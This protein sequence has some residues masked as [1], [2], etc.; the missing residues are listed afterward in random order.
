VTFFIA[1]YNFE[2]LLPDLLK[3]KDYAASFANILGIPN[4]LNSSVLQ[5]MQNMNRIL[6][7]RINQP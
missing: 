7:R 2:L 1:K 5:R 3:S 4:A 6:N